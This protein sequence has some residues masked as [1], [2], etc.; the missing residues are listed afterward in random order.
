MER[1]KMPRKVNFTRLLQI[2]GSEEGYTNRLDRSSPDSVRNIPFDVDITIYK[3]TRLKMNHEGCSNSLSEEC[4][5]FHRGYG[6]D[7]RNYTAP[8]RFPCY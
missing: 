8:S 3:E 4:I 2:F 1:S 7:G 5:N 6:G